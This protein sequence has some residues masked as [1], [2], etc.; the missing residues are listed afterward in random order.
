MLS[1]LVSILHN[2]MLNLGGRHNNRFSGVKILLN[3][4]LT[5]TE[6]CLLNLYKLNPHFMFQCPNWKHIKMCVPTLVID[7]YQVNR[8]YDCCNFGRNWVNF[9][10]CHSQFRLIFLIVPIYFLLLCWSG[11]LC[12]AVLLVKITFVLGR[13][14][15][16]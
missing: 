8:S 3:Q 11:C 2:T 14:P 13:L 6:I 15:L 16:K 12:C 5:E 1:V 10:L 9:L 7:H 4:D